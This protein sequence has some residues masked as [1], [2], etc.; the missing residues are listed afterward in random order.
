MKHILIVDD[1]EIVLEVLSDLL[2]H[3]SYEVYS[4]T[5]GNLGLNLLD[6]HP[7]DLV[8]LDLVIPNKEGLE[9]LLEIKKKHPNTLVIAMSGKSYH[10][11]F[12][13]LAAAKALGA[14]QTLKKP[15]STEQIIG[16]LNELF[17][18]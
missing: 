14:V 1:N 9:T 16:L 11:G 6:K 17:T 18:D 12:D 2:E 15:F 8:F 3:H 13:N 10:S 7:I 4:A 5:D